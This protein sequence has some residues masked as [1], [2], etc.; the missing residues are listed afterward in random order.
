MT[1]RQVLGACVALVVTIAAALVARCRP[2]GGGAAAADR[3]AVASWLECLDDCT[4]LLDSVLQRASSRTSVADS[5]ARWLL[6]GLTAAERATVTQILAAVPG[7]DT[8]TTRR[9]VGAYERSVR[10]RAAIALGALRSPEA[11]AALDSAL[12]LPLP[13]RIAR[14]V[15]R[16]RSDSTLQMRWRARVSP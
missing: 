16:A 10:V 12:R 11:L 9:D 15:A 8:A 7:S 2:T 13:P 6:S 5:L 1:R 14:A 4:P 3:A